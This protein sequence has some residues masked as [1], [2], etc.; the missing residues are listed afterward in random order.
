MR[1]EGKIFF[2]GGGGGGGGGG[3]V[4]WWRKVVEMSLEREVYSCMGGHT[5][6]C[7]CVYVADWNG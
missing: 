2:L 6:T 1:T 4:L 3:G 7:I 5:C